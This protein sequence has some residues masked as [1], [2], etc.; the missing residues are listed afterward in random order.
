MPE[1]MTTEGVSTE[2]DD[3]ESEHHRTDA[4]PEMSGTGG[5]RKPKSAPGIM[6]QHQNKD[7]RDI[8]KIPMNILQNEGERSFA[9]IPKARFPDCT[10]RWISPEGFVVRSAIIVP[11]ETEACRRPEN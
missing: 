8:E 9:R 6:R 10:S 11:G 1:R 3:V 5:I 7:Q 2:Q 4:K